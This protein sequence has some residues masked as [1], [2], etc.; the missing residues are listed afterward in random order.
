[1]HTGRLR[2]VIAL[3]NVNRFNE[4]RRGL[5]IG[6]GAFLFFLPD[7]VLIGNSDKVRLH[8]TI[9]EYSKINLILNDSPAFFSIL[10]K[11]E[12]SSGS[13]YFISLNLHS[14]SSY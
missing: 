3:G 6:G 10:E 2:L 5:V 4:S 8:R 9:L 12:R 13:T 11:N 14:K 1:M 7:C